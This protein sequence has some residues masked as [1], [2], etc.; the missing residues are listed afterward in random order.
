MPRTK[1]DITEAELAILEVLWE[2]GQ[3]SIRQ[4]VE[5][6][7][8]GRGQG[9]YASVQKQLERLE[10]KG[11][12]SRDR[13]LFVHL[14]KARADKDQIIGR[15]LAAIVQRLC[16]G[17]VAPIISHLMRTGGLSQAERRELRSL[18]ESSKA[19]RRSG[20]GRATRE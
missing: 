10:G 16:G 20:G 5:D 11:L 1:Q 2:R 12:V 6:L 4:I 9:Q 19:A 18:V 3:A 8:P 14:F 15:R 7:Y 13:S 17:S